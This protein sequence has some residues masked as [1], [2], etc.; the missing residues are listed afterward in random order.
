MRI[1][2]YGGLE[3]QV[4]NV[5]NYPLETSG[6]ISFWNENRAGIMAKISCIREASPYAPGALAF[7]TSANVDAPQPE[8][9]WS[10]KMRI[11]SAGNVG[12]GETDPGAKLHIKGDAGTNHLWIEESAGESSRTWM[13]ANARGS[14]GF[15][16]LGF[17][18]GSSQGAAPSTTAGIV[19]TEEGGATFAGRVIAGGG[20]D[21]LDG[22]YHGYADH[23]LPTSIGVTTTIQDIL[24]KY[25]TLPAGYAYRVWATY[26][27]TL[28]VYHNDRTWVGFRLDDASQNESGWSESD[29]GSVDNSSHA[30]S[31]YAHSFLGTSMWQAAAGSHH[32]DVY[33]SHADTGESRTCWRGKLQIWW[34]P[35]V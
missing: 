11:D 17:Y 10:E 31:N 8:G 6:S 21:N 13:I 18:V 25:F 30:Y 16:D 22:T 7:Y 27:I 35:I 3:L 33:C 28:D 26:S 15:G 14:V 19:F 24:T 5:G 20:V 4:P 12:I 23:D 32:I 9:A 1:P 34:S 29:V 2:Q